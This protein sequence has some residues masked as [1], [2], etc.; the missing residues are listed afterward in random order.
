M[1]APLVGLFLTLAGVWLIYAGATSRTSVFPDIWQGL[2]AG[3]RAVFNA[4]GLPL[5]DRKAR[6]VFDVPAARREAHG[7]GL[8]FIESDGGISWPDLSPAPRR[9]TDQQV[10]AQ[11]H[12]R[13]IAAQPAAGADPECPMC[14]GHGQVMLK[15]AVTR[16]PACYLTIK[17]QASEAGLAYPSYWEYSRAIPSEG[18]RDD[19][20]LR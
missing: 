11:I 19:R 16:C 17:I 3:I 8:P 4:F 15:G 6:P 2:K 12:A 7:L 14:D 20:E 9:P 10:H 18:N 1:I 5:I 13:R